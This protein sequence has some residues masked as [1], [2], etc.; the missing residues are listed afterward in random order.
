[1]KRLGKFILSLC[2][3]AGIGFAGFMLGTNMDTGSGSSSRSNQLI[4]DMASLKELLDRNFLFDVDEE[5]LYEGSL[6]GMFANLGDP[7]T[8][9]YPKEE[10][11][12]LIENLDGRYKG[13]GI[14]LSLIHI[15]EP[16]RPRFGSRM[17]S[18]A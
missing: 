11:A 8:A 15:S 17:P 4:S 14:S 9:Y 6:K 2:L 7:Y 16:T 18:S 12:K 3:V 1:M 13:I 10:F 5:K